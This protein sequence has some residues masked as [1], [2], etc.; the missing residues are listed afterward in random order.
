MTKPHYRTGAFMSGEKLRVLLSEVI[1][2]H[3]TDDDKCLVLRMRDGSALSTY[4]PM[5][6]P[7]W[8]Q[9]HTPPDADQ[10][11]QEIGSDD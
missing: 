9:Y 8:M 2:A 1:T 4:N 11:F 10:R 6:G 3:L 5:G 7:M